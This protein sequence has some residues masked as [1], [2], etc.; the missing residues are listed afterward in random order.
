[1]FKIIGTSNDFD[2]CENCGRENLKRVVVLG[3]LD[4]DGTSISEMRVGT[5]CAATLTG[6]TSLSSVKTLASRRN[7]ATWRTRWGSWFISGNLHEFT[8]E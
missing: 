8:A 6:K 1:M 3:V 4:A 7:A 2:S 5:Q